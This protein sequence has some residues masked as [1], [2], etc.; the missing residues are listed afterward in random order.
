[1]KRGMDNRH[2]V[3]PKALGCSSPN[4]LPSTE[5]IEIVETVQVSGPVVGW[6][7]FRT[8]FPLFLGGLSRPTRFCVANTEDAVAAILHHPPSDSLI[9]IQQFRPAALTSLV[10]QAA[11]ATD[12]LW[13]T[14]IVAGSLPC[15]SDPEITIR[16]EIAEETGC[17]VA[18]LQKINEFFA[19]PALLATRVHLFV[20]QIAELPQIGVHGREDE[21]EDI[22]VLLVPT[23]TAIQHALSGRLH[24]SLTLLAISLFALRRSSASHAREN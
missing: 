13:Q 9:L 12:L 1:M 3:T 7:E 18:N 17:K 4:S 11:P 15:G 8:R 20:A 24:N 6:T 2:G 22:R 5:H 21:G 14:E 19:N 16:Q 23:T 10:G